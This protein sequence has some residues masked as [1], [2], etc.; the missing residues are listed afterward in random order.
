MDLSHTLVHHTTSNVDA[1]LPNCATTH[2]IL[3]DKKYFSNISMGKSNVNTIS[4]PVDLIQGSGRATIILP[5]ETKIH[6]NDALYYAKSK[7]NLL[8]FKDI[9]QNGYHIETMNDDSNE[10]LLITLIISGG[11]HILEK[12]PS[13]SCGL[14]QT[15]I[16]PIESY[17]VMN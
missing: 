16:R 10:Y 4:G 3:R 11:K 14:Y 17:V 6:I 9:R 7:R 1:C 5:R 2:I 8:S 12:L 13:Y 15:I